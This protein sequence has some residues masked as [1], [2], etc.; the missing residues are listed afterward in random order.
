MITLYIMPVKEI[1]RAVMITVV[2]LVGVISHCDCH[3]DIYDVYCNY[4]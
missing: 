3:Q 2:V 4:E 1:Q